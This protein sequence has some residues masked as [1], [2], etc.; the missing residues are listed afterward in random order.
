LLFGRLLVS[1]RRLHQLP[2]SAARG[3]AHPAAARQVVIQNPP[4]V[5]H[6]RKPRAQ[7]WL[8]SMSKSVVAPESPEHL[9]DVLRESAFRNKSIAL[10]GNDSK[11]KM[12]GPAVDSE[13][14]VS[15]RSLGRVLQYEPKD[16]TIS[17]EAG[18]PFSRLQTLLDTEGQMI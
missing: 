12:A 1:E 10:A 9:A 6:R 11:L 17:V 3:G 8:I 14:V 2:C 5:R 15:T 16:L 13:V 4:Q 18:M 7:W